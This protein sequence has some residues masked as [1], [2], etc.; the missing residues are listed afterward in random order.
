MENLKLKGAISYRDCIFKDSIT[1]IKAFDHSCLRQ[2]KQIN[3]IYSSNFFSYLAINTFS[4]IGIERERAKNYNKFS[5]PYIDCD[6]ENIVSEIERLK[7]RIHKEK[8]SQLIDDAKITDYKS[9]IEILNKKIDDAIFNSLSIVEEEQEA[10]IIDYALD[11]IRPFII[12]DENKI[13]HAYSNLSFEDQYL[14]NYATLFLNRFK[15]T[16]DNNE[17]K[18]IAE[19]WHS[20]HIVGMLFKVVPNIPENSKDIVWIKKG[21]DLILQ[22]LIKLGSQKITDQLFV[23]KDIRGFEADY[24]Y[25]F[26]PNEKRLWHQAIGYLDVDEFMD[27]VLKAGRRGE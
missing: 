6:V 2:L 13:K 9:S 22:S 26:K 14:A 7:L 8:L 24:F 21:N 15:P 3:A 12:N 10:T 16:L 27:A 4:S 11:I 23:Q 1:S 17:Q 5:I 19:I 25:I 20:R 18:F